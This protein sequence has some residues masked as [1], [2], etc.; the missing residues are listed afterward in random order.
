MDPNKNAESQKKAE[1]EGKQSK[2]SSRKVEREPIPN[3]SLLFHGKIAFGKVPNDEMI[4]ELLGKGYNVFI[5]L[6]SEKESKEFSY[7]LPT[8]IQRIDFP[9]DENKGP[10]KPI[11]E[12]I[13]ECVTLLNNDKKKIYFHC[14]NGRGR[15]GVIVSCIIGT[16]LDIGADIAISI[17]N[18]GHRKGHGAY[19]KWHKHSIPSHRDQVRFI[20]EFLDGDGEELNDEDE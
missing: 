2:H 16:Y 14:K 10:A 12:L 15:T 7:T 8:E 19:R 3:Y 13:K 18:E 5:N 20:F 9:I 17:I 11:T 4:K 1:P 6:L